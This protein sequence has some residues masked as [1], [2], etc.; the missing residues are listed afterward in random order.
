LNAASLYD[1][2]SRGLQLATPTQDTVE[3][4][5]GAKEAVPL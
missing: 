1:I 5:A 3:V 2:D 4:A